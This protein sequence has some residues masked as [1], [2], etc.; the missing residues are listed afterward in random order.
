MDSLTLVQPNGRVIALDL[1]PIDPIDGVQCIQ[2]DFSDEGVLSTLLQYLGD[3]K[4]D[5]VISDMAPNM[6][7]NESVDIPRAMYLAELAVDFALSTLNSTGWFA[8]QSVS[9]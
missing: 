3:K 1:L 7:G 6:S 9:R 5:W 4:A 8:D 2:G